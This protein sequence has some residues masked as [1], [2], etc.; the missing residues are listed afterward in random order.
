M[1]SSKKSIQQLMA[2]MLGHGVTHVVLS[3]GSRNA[4]LI[5]CFSQHPSFKVYTLVDERSAS[6]FALGLILKLKQP[7]AVCCT[8]GTALLNY[9]SATAEAFYQHLPLLVISADRPPHWLGQADGQTINQQ[10]ALANFVQKSIVLSEVQSDD[11]LW[12]C[13]RMANEALIALT[14]GAGGPVHINLP[15]SEPLYD[16]TEQE[17]PYARKISMVTGKSE[18]PTSYVGAFGAYSRKMVIVGQMLPDKEVARALELFSKRGDTVVIAEHTANIPSSCTI[19]HFEQVLAA[20][21]DEEKGRLAPDLLITIGGHIVSKRLKL[22]IRR[23]RPVEH[24]HIGSNVVDTYQSLTDV[25]DVE[26]VVFLKKMAKVPI[27]SPDFRNYWNRRNGEVAQLSDKFLKEVPYSDI[28]VYWTIFGKLPKQVSLHLGNSTPVRYAQL[29]S[30]PQVTE[31]HCNRG[32][33]GIDGV[34][35]TFTGYSVD[36]NKLSILIIGELSFLYDSNGLWNRYLSPKCRIVVI[37]NGGGGI[38]RIID[39]PTKSEALESHIEYH[40][41]QSVEGIAATFGLRYLAAKS[42]DELE[43]QLKVFLNEGIDEPMLLE[44]FTPNKENATIYKSYFENLKT[45]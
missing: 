7:V 37:N 38:F 13:N 18:I 16:F 17:L 33:S 6:Y 43:K 15:I 20:M 36:A 39:G 23:N 1:Y 41:S 42:K 14:A 28:W 29:F 8:S 3:P 24:W 25:M 11:D 12:L 30:L 19:S 44:V 21:T 31:V 9:S 2:L 27:M 22:F 34:V 10:N 5:H 32:T 45:T 35:S 26:P 4:P 40:H